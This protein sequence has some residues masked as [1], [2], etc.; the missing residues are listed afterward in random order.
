[1]EQAGYTKVAI[2]QFEDALD[3]HKLI[4]GKLKHFERRTF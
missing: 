2:R 1:M 3:T 4:N